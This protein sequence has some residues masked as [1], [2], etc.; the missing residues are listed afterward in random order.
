MAIETWWII[1]HQSGEVKM[2]MAETAFKAAELMKWPFQECI[3]FKQLQADETAGAVYCHC[4]ESM[5]SGMPC[6]PGVCPNR[7]RKPELE[8]DG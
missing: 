1:R 2:E 5:S 3:K 6:K 7:P 4:S 8:M